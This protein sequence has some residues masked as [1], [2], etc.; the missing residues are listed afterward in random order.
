MAFSLCLIELYVSFVSRNYT[1]PCLLNSFP[2]FFGSRPYTLVH[3]R[4]SACLPNLLI[5]VLAGG[6]M[7]GFSCFSCHICDWWQWSV[8]GNRTSWHEHPSVFY[9]CSNLFLFLLFLSVSY[10][11]SSCVA[12][13]TY[14]P[15]SVFGM[16]PLVSSSF[17]FFLH[18]ITTT[19]TTTTTT[20]PCFGRLVPPVCLSV[21]LSASAAAYRIWLPNTIEWNYKVRS[22]HGSCT[23][24]HQPYIPF[25]WL[26]GFFLFILLCF[27]HKTFTRSLRRYYIL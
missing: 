13:Y 22:R 27:T 20:W 24:Y 17:L 3:A 4:L 5:L 16:L 7:G 15:F 19:T 14:L 21:C 9:V 18:C 23:A 1:V 25:E 10:V 2:R 12:L 26:P 11:W 8:N 6:S